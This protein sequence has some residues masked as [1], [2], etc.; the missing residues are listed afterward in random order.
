MDSHKDTTRGMV[1]G[2]GVSTGF[3]RNGQKSELSLLL[4][5]E[6]CVGPAPLSP[7]DLWP[8]Y[9]SPLS[10]ESLTAS[11]ES[12]E[13]WLQEPVSRRDFSCPHLEMSH[14]GSGH[15]E[16]LASRGRVG[17]RC[18]SLGGILS[19]LDGK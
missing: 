12:K 13:E 7:S 1:S 2:A 10:T 5:E 4:E 15:L 6:S 16:C 11:Q 18:K 8:P 9:T 3:C 17:C 14:M 19:G